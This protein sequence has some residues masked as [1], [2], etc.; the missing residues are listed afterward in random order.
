[1]LNSRPNSTAR[2]P[3]NGTPV[4][5][6]P[7]RIPTYFCTEIEEQIQA[8]VQDDTIEKVQAHGCP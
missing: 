6:P 5:I 4:K 7:Q 2:T 3:N 8:M 1:L